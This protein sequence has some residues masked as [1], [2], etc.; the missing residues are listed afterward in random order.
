[1]QNPLASPKTYATLTL[2]NVLV[3]VFATTVPGVKSNQNFYGDYRT[4]YVAGEAARVSPDRIYD[5]DTQVATQKAK[6]G[7]SIFLPFFH[8][9]L[10]LLLFAPLSKLSYLQSINVWRGLSVAFLLLSGWLIARATK[11]DVLTTTLM[12]ASL[13][14]VFVCLLVGQ[15]GLLTSLLI[16]ATFYL[17][18][19]EQDVSAGFVLALVVGFKPQ[20]PVILALALFALG[21]RK[22]MVSFV[23]S[24]AVITGAA[25]AYMGRTGIRGLLDCARRTEKELTATLM[26]TIRGLLAKLAGDHHAITVAALI[27]F[28]VVFFPLW[29]WSQSLDFV[30]STAICVSSFA[31]LHGY[32]YDMTVLA[33]PIALI[34][35]APRKSDARFLAP[36]CSA[37]LYFMLLYGKLVSLLVLPTILLCIACFRLYPDGARGILAHVSKWLPDFIKKPGPE[38]TAAVTRRRPGGVTFSVRRDVF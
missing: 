12:A 19:G 30:F 38:P 7:D 5:W 32:A 26:P 4:Y 24:C 13:T 21:R 8:P 35:K 28:L 34:L 25:L 15:D 37:P 31:A 27:A 10:E 18:H 9:P 36:L 11:S 33:I 6:F 17:L 14:P 29:R 23:A 3:L 1:M 2:I 20:I 16:A 22:F